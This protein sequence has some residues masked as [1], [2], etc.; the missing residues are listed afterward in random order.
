MG[1]WKSASH[2]KYLLQYHLIFVC[3]YRKK[4]LISQ[5]VSDDIK[6]LSREI[7][8]KHN[9]SIKY[10]EVDKD[11]IHYMIETKPNIN[12]SDFVRTMKSYTTYHIWQK[13]SPYL[14]NYFWK[15]HTFW[16]DGYFICSVGNVSEKT[17]KEYIENQG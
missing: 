10:M 12:L 6:R 15:E 13:Y 16:T 2:N 17:L 14:S 3:K 11:H 7:C 4:L 9:V 1:N 5:Y 8:Y